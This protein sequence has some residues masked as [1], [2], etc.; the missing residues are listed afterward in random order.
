[1][2]EIIDEAVK[3]LAG[4]IGAGFEGVVKFVLEGEG[5]IMVEA[6]SVEASGHSGGLADAKSEP[7]ATIGA[8]SGSW[9]PGRAPDTSPPYPPLPRRPSTLRVS[10]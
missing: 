4:R 10:R 1:M 5:A 8:P 7:V 2:S 6:L 3:A 9:P